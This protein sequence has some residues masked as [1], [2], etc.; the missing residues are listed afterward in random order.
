MNSA[1][2]P[3]QAEIG[4]TGP[5]ACAAVSSDR[6]VVVPTATTRP[7]RARVSAMARAVSGGTVQV[8][9]WISCA[10]RSSTLTGRNVSRPT[11][12]VT[13]ASPT[14][15]ACSAASSSGVKCRPAVGAAAEPGWSP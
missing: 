14:P 6:T 8:S 15:R 12:S 4:G 1:V 3:D 13:V 10:R 2:S 11:C 5:A 7:P 9:R